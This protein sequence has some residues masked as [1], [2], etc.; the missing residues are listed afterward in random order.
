MDTKIHLVGKNTVLAKNIIFMRAE[1]N[2][3][4][5]FLLN[6]QKIVIS[7]TLK[8]LETKFSSLNFFRPHKSFLINLSHVQSFKPNENNKISLTNDFEV[9]LSRRKKNSFMEVYLKIK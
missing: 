1:A 2:Y 4:E 3:S 9:V 6:G 5:I 8:Q 7:K